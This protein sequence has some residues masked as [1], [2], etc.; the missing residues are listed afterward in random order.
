MDPHPEA[1]F[2]SKGPRKPALSLT[3]G[4][5]QRAL[6][7]R[8]FRWNVLRGPFGAPQEEADRL[9]KQA[10]SDKNLRGGLAKISGFSKTSAA[11]ACT[12]DVGSAALAVPAIPRSRVGRRRRRAAPRAKFPQAEPKPDQEKPR[13][14]AWIFL[15]FFVRF[16][17]FQWV[18]SN[19]EKKTSG[20]SGREGSAA[21]VRARGGG[22][23]RCASP[24]APRARPPLGAPATA[25]THLKSQGTPSPPPG[26][27]PGVARS[28]GWG[29]A[30]CFDPS[31]IARTSPRTYIGADLLSTPHPAFGHLPR[32]AEKGKPT[33]ARNFMKNVANS[34]CVN[35]VGSPKD[36]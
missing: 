13:K 27:D 17:A 29:M 19:P 2:A 20:A 8:R 14:R 1:P 30:R 7:R 32:F 35:S 28:A 16:G 22:G 12:S 36:E 18:T 15:D 9:S 33:T 4:M 3:K 21:W 5:L 10:L 34:T 31:R 23:A 11:P 25:F 26:L 6:A 24:A